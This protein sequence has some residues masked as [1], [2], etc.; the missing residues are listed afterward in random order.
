L[1]A[2]FFWELFFGELGEPL[3]ALVPADHFSKWQSH[4]TFYNAASNFGKVSSYGLPWCVAHAS[5]FPQIPVQTR[6]NYWIPQAT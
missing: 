3:S 6:A 5:T 2:Q 4:V 1:T